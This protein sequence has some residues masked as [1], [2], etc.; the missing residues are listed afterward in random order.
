MTLTKPGFWVMPVEI[1][2][3][4]LLKPGAWQGSGDG[5]RMLQGYLSLDPAR[6]VRVRIHGE[7]AWMTIKGLTSGMTRTEIEFPLD[8]GHARELISLCHRPLIDKTR[9]RQNHA[10]M[11]WEIDVFHAENEGLVVAEIELPG[12][13][14]EFSLPEWVGLEVTGDFRYSNASLVE[15]PFCE[16]RENHPPG[17]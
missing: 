16:W 11:V 2:R 7:C 3:K 9:Y 4:F 13:D 12:E 15:H 17:V 8:P 5:V 10:G 6:T 1:E 14:H